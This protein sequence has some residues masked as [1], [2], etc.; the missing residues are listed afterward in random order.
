MS[1]HSG[2]NVGHNVEQ[3]PNY[4][5]TSKADLASQDLDYKSTTGSILHTWHSSVDPEVAANASVIEGAH[6]M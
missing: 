4:K 2:T 1:L 6:F 5:A 3:L